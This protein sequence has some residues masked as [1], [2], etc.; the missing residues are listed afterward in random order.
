MRPTRSG[1]PRGF[2]LVE[3][4]VVIVI[5]ALLA[6]LITPVVFSAINNAKEAQI[7]IEMANLAMAI[8]DYKRIVGAYPPSTVAD[9]QA[10]V[11]AAFPF[12]GDAAAEVAAFD[13]DAK[14]LTFWLGGVSKDPTKPFTGAGRKS[15]EFNADRIAANGS[16]L[17]PI[18]TLTQPYVYTKVS[19][20][21]FT[22]TQAGLDDI[23]GGDDELKYPE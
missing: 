13:A 1:R 21:E 8:E 17:P 5:L 16:Y 7:K 10:H 12:V 19:E 23:P 18:E 20:S 2:T 3:L 6:G 4:L 22:I 14:A 9:A 11:A 15:F